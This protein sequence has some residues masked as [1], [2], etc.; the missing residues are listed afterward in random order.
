MNEQYEWQGY[1]IDKICIG[2]GKYSKVYHGY[3]IKTNREIAVKK[4][5]F[6]K[7]QNKLKERVITEINILQNMNHKNIIK[8]YDYKF[9][10]EYILLIMEY[11]N[12]GDLGNWIKKNPKEEEIS[13]VIT[14]I[15]D[16]IYYLHRNN[17]I[18]RDIKPENMMFDKDTI[19][20]CDFGF[21]KIIKDEFDL[22]ETMC[23]TPLFMS[24]EILFLTPYNI[25]SEI[26]SL[27]VLLYMI[28]LGKHPFGY[29][30]NLEN[31]RKK[32]KDRELIDFQDIYIKYKGEFILKIVPIIKNMLNYSQEQ[33]PSIK[34]IY[35]KLNFN[36]NIND[37]I[38]MT[39]NPILDLTS[40]ISPNPFSPVYILPGTPNNS[41]RTPFR[42]N[43]DASDIINIEMI[44][45]QVENIKDIKDI[46]S[47]DLNEMDENY[48]KDEYIEEKDKIKS[49]PISIKNNNKGIVRKIYDIISKSF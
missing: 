3:E 43:S 44:L 19:K 39:D 14:N 5:Y 1:M 37:I 10:G 20:I 11:C 34:D 18:H 17:I 22:L 41:Y 25:N 33:R 30:E 26:W 35:N 38:N 15:I 21:S 48:F 27:G 49:Q 8:L 47:F 28:L 7:L 16:G 31:Y 24:P 36:D 46:E 4:I 9:D 32:I 40:I 12:G 42:K 13:N 6:D 29:L 23:G 2:K 45:K